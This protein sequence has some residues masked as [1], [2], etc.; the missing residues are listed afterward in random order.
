MQY[1]CRTYILLALHRSCFA[2]RQAKPRWLQK[3]RFFISQAAFEQTAKWNGPGVTGAALQY[4]AL[5]GSR[6]KFV[7]AESPPVKRRAKSALNRIWRQSCSNRE[8]PGHAPTG[9]VMADVSH[10]VPTAKHLLSWWHHWSG[11]G[12]SCK[13]LGRFIPL[14]IRKYQISWHLFEFPPNSGDWGAG[15]IEVNY[16]NCKLSLMTSAFF[17]YDDVLVSMGH[18]N[19]HHFY[20]TISMYTQVL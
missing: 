7:E 2:V 15:E 3:I 8:Q 11:R 5:W 4:V 12:V 18:M 10:Q 17:D 9:D 14:G 16:L 19:I 1:S 20:T 6:C 13:I